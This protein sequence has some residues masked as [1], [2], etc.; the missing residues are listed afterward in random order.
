MAAVIFG[1][2]F[3]GFLDGD[4][5]IAFKDFP[6]HLAAKQTAALGADVILDHTRTAVRA[7]P[8]LGLQVAVSIDIKA[9]LILLRH[10]DLP[11]ANCLE[12]WVRTHPRAFFRV[13]RMEV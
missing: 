8:A 2:I 7:G 11:T 3:Q 9:A 6:I 4:L 13:H 10:G 1:E 5:V 12:I